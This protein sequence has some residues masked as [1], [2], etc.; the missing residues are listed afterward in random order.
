M[1]KIYML[2]APPIHVNVANTI[3][4]TKKIKDFPFPTQSTPGSTPVPTTSGFPSQSTRPIGDAAHTGM[5]PNGRCD[6]QQQK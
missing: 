2:A 5:L 3:A 6:R 1:K 4:A